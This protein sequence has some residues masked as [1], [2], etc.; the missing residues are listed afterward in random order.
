MSR[1]LV[2]EG[3]RR[4]LSPTA[5]RPRVKPDERE[6]VDRELRRHFP[7]EFVNRLDDVIVFDPLDEESML[8]VARILLRETAEHLLRQRLKVDR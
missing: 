6:I 8:E 2:A 7:P 1:D 3:S 4:G 5:H